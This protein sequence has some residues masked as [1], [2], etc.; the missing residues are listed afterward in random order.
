MVSMYVLPN[1]YAFHF[2]TFRHKKAKIDPSL[3]QT[4]APET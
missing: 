1:G 3:K 4:S 2:L